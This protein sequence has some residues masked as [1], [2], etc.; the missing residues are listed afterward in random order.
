MGGRR[1][2]SKVDTRWETY[3]FSKRGGPRKEK[4][5]VPVGHRADT[6]AGLRQVSQT[7]AGS[8]NT[9][10]PAAL[11]PDHRGRTPRRGGAESGRRSPVVYL[12]R[13]GN[14]RATCLSGRVHG[15]QRS[16][17]SA[18]T[19]RGGERSTCLR[20][21]VGLPVWAPRGLFIQIHSHDFSPFYSI[22]SVNVIFICE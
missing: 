15:E 3:C 13:V 7:L 18:G 6:L 11:Q 21:Q 4:G 16:V 8:K 5:R 17:G 20:A 1:G 2:G 22:R 9:F 14:A 12:C 10:S 19:L